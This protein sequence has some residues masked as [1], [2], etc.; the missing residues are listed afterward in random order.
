MMGQRLILMA[1][2]L[3]GLVVMVGPGAIAGGLVWFAFNRMIG[4]VVFVPAAVVCLA[5]VAIEVLVA[6]EALGPAY[7]RM[8]LSDVERG[9]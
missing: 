1:G 3:L 2:V 9:E 6:T 7:E 5:L 8:D 4:A